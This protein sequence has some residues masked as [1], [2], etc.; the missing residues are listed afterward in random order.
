MEKCKFIM[1]Y[2]RVTQGPG[3][4]ESG[5]VDY[6]SYS[7]TGSYVIDLG[8]RDLG[9]DLAYA[10]CE[11]QVKRVY[12]SCNTVWFESVGSVQCADGKARNLVFMLSHINSEDLNNLGLEVG[13]VFKQGQAF[14][15]EGSAGT[16]GSHIHLEVGE[17]P[18]TGTGQS[19]T[20]LK[21]R[22]GQI[23]Y[24]INKQL[25]P[26]DVFFIGPQIICLD[27]GGLSWHKE[28]SRDINIQTLEEE[29]AALREKVK[30]LVQTLEKINTIVDRL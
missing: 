26:Q 18:F 11:V 23:V 27:E 24:K 20:Q 16:I 15:K 1:D 8:G 5:R 28:D 10:P 30:I 4:F 29:N 12:G 13:K 17:G 25:R 2:L 3:V 14:Y 7:H 6:T 19:K 9:E 22:R 21:N